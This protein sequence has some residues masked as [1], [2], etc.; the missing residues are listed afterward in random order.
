MSSIS[1]EEISTYFNVPFIKRLIGLCDNFCHTIIKSYVDGGRGG[2]G[3][4]RSL[5][6]EGKGKKGKQKYYSAIK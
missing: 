5:E 4:K 3:K 1:N 6:K 2:G